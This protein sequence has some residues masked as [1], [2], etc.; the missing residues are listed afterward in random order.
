VQSPRATH[1]PLERQAGIFRRQGI[2]LAP[3]T[4]GD[5]VADGATLLTPIAAAL[6]AA[7]LE[8]HVLTIDDT[9]LRVL[10]RQHAD[11]V[12]RGHL[13]GL[14]GDRRLVA[15]AYTPTWEGAAARA[16][17]ATRRGWLHADGYAGF[18][19]LFTRPGATA[20]EVGCWAHTRRKFVAA[21][22]A[23][24]VHAAVPLERIRQLYALEREATAAGLDP[25][26]RQ[27][28]RRARAAPILDQLARWV[29]EVHPAVPPRSPLG[30]AF[31]Y[32]LAQWPVLRR[33]LEDG[34]LPL[35]TNDVERA[36][37]AVALG[38]KNWL[39]AGSDAGARRA[40]VIYSVLGS[41]VLCDVEPW[42]YLRAVLLT[43]N[44]TSF[45]Q[46]RVRELLPD[47]WGAAH[48]EARLAAAAA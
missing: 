8:A 34:A 26:T 37:R 4:L 15:F 10:D 36:L 9:G 38:R 23:G 41:C 14:V 20:I 48:P 5:W 32:L 47:V 17:V 30:K 33:F 40:A 16:L 6:Y 22:D 21:L 27:Q 12:K 42:A 19:Q 46:S 1:L 25:P 13:W 24:E 28:L 29:A 43:L 18:D 7:V 35:D 2:D 39:F 44:G 45:P 31:H 11:G 3:S